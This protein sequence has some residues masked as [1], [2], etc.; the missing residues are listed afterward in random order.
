MIFRELRAWIDNENGNFSERH[1]EAKEKLLAAK[2]KVGFFFY[3][4]SRL[5]CNY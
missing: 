2:E 3:N 4:S 5:S 1:K